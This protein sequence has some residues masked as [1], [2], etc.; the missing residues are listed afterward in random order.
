[1]IWHYFDVD[2]YF[3]QSELEVNNRYPDILLLERNPFK[4]NYRYL[5][6]L[7]YSKK[8]LGQ[9]GLDEK[10]E[11]GIKQVQ[12]YLQLP[13]IKKLANLQACLIVSNGL[14]GAGSGTG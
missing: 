2:V 14:C 12:K 7:K 10:K 11:Q 9:Q 3:I 5:L 1:L 4:V 8:S 13:E 6:E